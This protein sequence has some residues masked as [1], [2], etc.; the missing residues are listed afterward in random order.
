MICFASLQ[1]MSVALC[2][3]HYLQGTSPPSPPCGRAAATPP[4]A[5]ERHAGRR[6]RRPLRERGTAQPGDRA[7]RGVGTFSLITLQCAHWRELPPL[8]EAQTRRDALG[9]PRAGAR[10]ELARQRLRGEKRW[11][12]Q[13]ALRRPAGMVRVRPKRLRVRSNLA[14]LSRAPAPTGGTGF[15]ARHLADGGEL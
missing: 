10:G 1:R 2:V 7:R 9:S 5:K 8:G 15:A 6:G 11:T 14:G 4:L 13:Q 12:G 3:W